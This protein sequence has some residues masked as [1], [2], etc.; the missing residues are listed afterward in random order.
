MDLV[1]V[2]PLCKLF[3]MHAKADEEE[4]ELRNWASNIDYK[5]TKIAFTD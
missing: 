5:R 2:Y 1:K 3:E 4:I